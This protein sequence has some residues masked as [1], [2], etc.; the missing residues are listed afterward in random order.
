MHALRDRLG[1][2]PPS[3]LHLALCTLHCMASGGRGTTTTTDDDD[4]KPQGCL[5]GATWTEHGESHAWGNWDFPHASWVRGKE[6]CFAR[7]HEAGW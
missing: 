6:L 7:F 2:G 5:Q 4:D 1:A 3:T